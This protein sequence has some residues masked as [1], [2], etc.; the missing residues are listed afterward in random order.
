MYWIVRGF[1]TILAHQSFLLPPLLCGFCADTD[2]TKDA[3]GA[4]KDDPTSSG[5]SPGLGVK[6][7][8][9][10]D[11]TITA[12]L[13]VKLPGGEKEFPVLNGDLAVSLPCFHQSFLVHWGITCNRNPYPT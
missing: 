11:V 1:D 8:G 7:E 2:L 6:I 13:N 3:G 10:Y 9:G 12:E 4:C 5:P